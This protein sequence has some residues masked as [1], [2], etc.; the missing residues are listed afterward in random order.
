MIAGD[1]AVWTALVGLLNG[2]KCYVFH[3]VHEVSTLI[4]SRV[5]GKLTQFTY[6]YAFSY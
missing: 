6:I 4:D 3:V 5:D 1:E 2:R